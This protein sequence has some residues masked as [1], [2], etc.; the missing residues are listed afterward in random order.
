MRYAR[1]LTV[2][3]HKGAE[4]YYQILQPSA[5]FWNDS[6]I[7]PTSP[8]TLLA[9]LSTPSAAFTSQPCYDGETLALSRRLLLV[10]VPTLHSRS[11]HL[12]IAL[13]LHVR[14]Q[15]LENIQSQDMVLHLS[16]HRLFQYVASP[17]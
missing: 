7:N 1:F 10:E 14:S 4:S 6:P 15:Q 2:T 9:R 12:H 8:W 13:H 16:L 17:A 11:S 3:E 5:S